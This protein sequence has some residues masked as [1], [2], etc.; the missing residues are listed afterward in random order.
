MLE[1]FS[2][3]NDN[4]P[5]Y[6]HSAQGSQT[7]LSFFSS[8]WLT[9]GVNDGSLNQWQNS[10]DFGLRC[11]CGV[12]P[13]VLDYCSFYLPRFRFQFCVLGGV[14]RSWMTM[15]FEFLSYK[16]D[17][18]CSMLVLLLLRARF[19]LVVAFC[20]SSSSESLP[21][22]EYMLSEVSSSSSTEASRRTFVRLIRFCL[23]LE[24]ELCACAW[25]DPDPVELLVW[26]WC[27]VSE[28]QRV[29][30][31][32]HGQDIGSKGKQLNECTLQ[33]RD[34]ANKCIH[35]QARQCSCQFV[36][37]Q[38][39]FSYIQIKYSAVSMKA[40]GLVSEMLRILQTTKH[41]ERSGIIPITIGGATE[42]TISSKPR[43][44]TINT[45]PH[46]RIHDWWLSTLGSDTGSLTSLWKWHGQDI[47]VLLP[48][49]DVYPGQSTHSLENAQSSFPSLEQYD[50]SSGSTG[51]H[52][53]HFS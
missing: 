26:T 30:G 28:K 39:E 13:L 43:C 42:Q 25:F 18:L 20:S 11:R 16:I 21:D 1:D 8:L 45:S 48:S 27:L 36:V 2:L 46:S 53:S 17:L 24:D 10:L 29:H 52:F 50:C 23:P 35:A 7:S 32:Y 37:D 14:S 38:V 41:L 9:V 3:A 40:R 31:A 51:S 5:S 6:V 15:S 19:R 47:N 12:A 22:S 49:S 44:D 33:A 4:E 34:W